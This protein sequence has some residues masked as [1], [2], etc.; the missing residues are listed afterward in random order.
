MNKKM[1]EILSKMESKRNSVK[2]YMDGE[3]KNLEKA[4]AIMDEVDML[5]KEYDIE[6]RLYEGEKADNAP[7]DEDLDNLANKTAT[8][9]FGVMTKVINA[10]GN[11][12]SL[13][14]AEKSLIVDGTNGENYLVPADVK[15]EINELRRH[16]VSAK[17]IVNVV[18]VST[19]SGTTNWE[20]TEDAG[21]LSA[22]TKD[23]EEISESENPTFVQKGWKIDF[24]GKLIPI[25]RSLLANEKASLMSYINRWFLK[26]AINSENKAIFEEL[27]KDKTVKAIK[28]WAALK[29]AINADLDPSIKLTSFI[30]TNQSG[31][32]ILDEEVDE[33]GRPILAANPA[34][35]TEK[36]FQGLQ[37][38]VFS[39]AQLPNV[40]NK[41]P[42]FIGDTREGIDFM[43][44]TTLEFAVSEHYLFNK[45]M[46]CM[47]IIEGFDVVGTDKDAYVYAT[48][49]PTPAKP[50]PAV[51]EAEINA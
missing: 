17:T 9:G 50:A 25:S 13:G 34:N 22:L 31:F 30:V 12:T 24:Y 15:L 21:E 4:A 16:H 3:T 46:N 29:R 41:S 8:S 1:R 40:S 26:K 47:R 11:L 20:S 49:E 39:D 7:N 43:D 5:Q 51:Q 23:G 33:N 48:F 14:D 36:L 44:R 2:E 6:K 18:P 28:G 27:K 32:A 35:A 38:V 10:K 37:I 19:L 45:N 42:M